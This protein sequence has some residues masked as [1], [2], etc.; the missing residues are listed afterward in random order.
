MTTTKDSLLPSREGQASVMT[1]AGDNDDVASGHWYSPAE[2]RR[3]ID[4]AR[5]DELEACK[6]V[7]ENVISENQRGGVRNSSYID[8]R[9]MGALACLVGIKALHNDKG[10]ES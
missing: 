9:E 10:N 7:C 8:G 2:V 4:V 6:A 3:L 5:L 1:M